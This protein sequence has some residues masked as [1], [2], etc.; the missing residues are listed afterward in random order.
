MYSDKEYWN[1]RYTKTKG[2][3]YDYITPYEYLSNTIKSLNLRK[4]SKIL[5]S[6][7]GSSLIP[8]KLHEEGYSFIT[9][10]DFSSVIIEDLKEKNKGLKSIQ[11]KLIYN[12]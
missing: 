1:K 4:E 9:C 5:I 10:V 8:E 2:L 12:L 7:C 6:G 11:C 3:P